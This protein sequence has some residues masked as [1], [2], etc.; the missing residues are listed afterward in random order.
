MGSNQKI[1]ELTEW[2]PKYNMKSGLE[3]TIEWF[4]NTENLK[5]YKADIYNL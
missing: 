2:T 5:N 4:K 1:K 3:E